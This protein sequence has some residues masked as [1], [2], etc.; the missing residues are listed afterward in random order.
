MMHRKYD[1]I[2]YLTVQSHMEKSG[3]HHKEEQEKGNVLR[4]KESSFRYQPFF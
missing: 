1:I 3:I 4:E 2:D